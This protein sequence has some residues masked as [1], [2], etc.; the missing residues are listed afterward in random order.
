[1]SDRV[2]GTRLRTCDTSFC[3]FDQAHTLELST[4]HTHASPAQSD[5]DRSTVKNKYYEE[6]YFLVNFKKKKKG[7]HRLDFCSTLLARILLPMKKG[8]AV[9]HYS[10]DLGSTAMVLIK[11]VL[12]C[13]VV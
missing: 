5:F 2:G 8:R 3:M 4:V 7:I 13:H 1:M 9:A 11:A 12:A 6:Q 10:S